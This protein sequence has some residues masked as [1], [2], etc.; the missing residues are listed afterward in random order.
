[1]HSAH[2]HHDFTHNAIRGES[3]T[4]SMSKAIRCGFRMCLAR[5]MREAEEQGVKTGS[6]L[7]MDCMHC[8]RYCLQPRG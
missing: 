2:D 5:H 6:V 1:R 4:A 7:P 3:T 8:A